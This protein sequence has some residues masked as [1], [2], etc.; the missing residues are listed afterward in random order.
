MIPSL[1]VLYGEE[2]V[3]LFEQEMSCRKNGGLCLGMFKRDC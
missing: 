1:G 3:L 2:E